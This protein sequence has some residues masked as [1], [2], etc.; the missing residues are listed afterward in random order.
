MKGKYIENLVDSKI[1]VV[2]FWYLLRC[3]RDFEFKMGSLWVDWDSRL[4]VR[5]GLISDC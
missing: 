4:T 5:F 3:I 2:M 1:T